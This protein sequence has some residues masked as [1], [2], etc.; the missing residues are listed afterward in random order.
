MFSVMF[1]NRYEKKNDKSKENI[2]SLWISYIIKKNK[3]QLLIIF[4]H[5]IFNGKLLIWLFIRFITF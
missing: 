4:I 5:H 3:Q 1:H 2:F